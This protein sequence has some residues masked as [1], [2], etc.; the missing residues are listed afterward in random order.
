MIDS[1]TF[2]E[3]SYNVLAGR[4]STYGNDAMVMAGA[5]N[6]NLL[7]HCEQCVDQLNSQNIV[8]LA[9]VVTT[10]FKLVCRDEYRDARVMDGLRFRTP[11][12]YGQIAA[13][14]GGVPVNIPPTD[15]FEALQRGMADCTFGP[16][17]HIRNYS[18]Y[19][20]ARYVIDQSFGMYMSGSVF[21]MNQRTWRSLRSEE[22]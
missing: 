13:K 7:L 4:V 21:N 12:S 10:P 14:W 19:E 17:A 15:M 11:G 2:A 18:L 22:H 1:L 9:Y 5:A 3:Q 20:V 16:E 6:E 8:P